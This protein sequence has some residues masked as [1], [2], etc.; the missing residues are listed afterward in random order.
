MKAPSDKTLIK[1]L[2][3]MERKLLGIRRIVSSKTSGVNRILYHRVSVLQDE[4][5]Y[6]QQLAK[7]YAKATKAEAVFIKDR[8]LEELDYLTTQIFET[9]QAAYAL[10]GA[11]SRH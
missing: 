7:Q 11:T 9:Q 8:L 10:A 4:L 6:A 2:Q 3:D 1:R 5:T